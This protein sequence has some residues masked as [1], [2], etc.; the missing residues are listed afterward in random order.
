[1]RDHN[2]ELQQFKHTS[3]SKKPRYSLIPKESL[4]SLAE[5]FELGDKKHGDKAWNALTNQAGLL[6][7]NWI[8][9]RAEHV[10]HHAMLYIQKLKGIIPDDG[11]D[12]GGAIMWGGACLVASKEAR[13]RNTVSQRNSERVRPSS[14]VPRGK[15]KK[16]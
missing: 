8:I 11:D 12:D 2:E 6:D 3:S 7:D 5:R 9:A 4:D 15:R 16:I 13:R 1:M 14:N 10:I